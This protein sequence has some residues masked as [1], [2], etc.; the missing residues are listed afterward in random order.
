LR[1]IGQLERLVE[2]NA[3]DDPAKA[4]LLRKIALLRTAAEAS[5]RR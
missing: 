4:R 2:A 5:R 3:I 1:E